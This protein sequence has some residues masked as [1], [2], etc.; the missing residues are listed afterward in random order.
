MFAWF[1]ARCNDQQL[2]PR[3]FKLSRSTP[4]GNRIRSAGFKGPRRV[5]APERIELKEQAPAAGIEPATKRLTVAL[6]YQHRTHRNV[7]WRE[8]DSN[9]RPPGYE[10]G[11]LPTAPSRKAPSGSRTHTSAMARQQATA[12]SWAQN[13]I[14][15]KLSKIKEGCRLQVLDFRRWEADARRLI[16]SPKPKAQVLTPK[17]RAPSRNRTDIPS[18]RRRYL[19]A[20]RSVLVV[21]QWDR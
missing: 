9:H 3:C 20:R 17:L 16:Q 14:T 21:I 6:P 15:T 1:R 4:S 19:P 18:L 10:P 7:K 2:P 5:Y 12:T 13:C 8:T 11:E